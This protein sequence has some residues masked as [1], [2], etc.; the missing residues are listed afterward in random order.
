MAALGRSQAEEAHA[1][2]R[3]ATGQLHRAFPTSPAALSTF[4]ALN[5]FNA[6]ALARLGRPA[7]AWHSWKL[8]HRSATALGKNHHHP[9]TM[10]GAANV[11]IYSVALHIETG[12]AATA[13]KNAGRIDLATIPS[14]NRRAQH[15]IDLAQG[16]LRRN[17]PDAAI[18]ALLASEQQST[19]T[20]A[21]N[22]A[23]H[24][25]IMEIIEGT[26][27]PPR[28]ALDLAARI[29]KAT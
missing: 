7:D 21:F 15:L 26:K 13:I 17:E 10:F 24:T 12:Q 14:T 19:E 28:A 16:H 3:D 6:I 11:A 1:I 22:R 20:I 23:A 29:L 27:R 2:A 8:A 25:T 4:G 5:L 18:T 9:L